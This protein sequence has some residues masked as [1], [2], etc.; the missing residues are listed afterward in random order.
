MIHNQAAWRA[1]FDFKYNNGKT[2][3]DI[4]EERQ[5]FKLLEMKKLG[6]INE[7]CILLV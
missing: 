7:M 1:N 5:L 3:C 2:F 4:S 6:N